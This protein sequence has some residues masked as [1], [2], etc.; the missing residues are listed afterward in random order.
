[1]ASGAEAAERPVPQVV[2]GSNGERADD[3]LINFW[4]ALG[5]DSTPGGK[6]ANLNLIDVDV[7]GAA[8]K[9]AA[10]V[11][12]GSV[13]GA[14]GAGYERGSN[15][16]SGSFGGRGG[17]VNATLNA[18][19]SGRGDQSAQ[20]PRFWVYSRGGVGGD[21]QKSPG[22]G[23]DAGTA[24]LT[25]S[26][27]V[28]T[29]GTAFQGVRVTS[30]GGNAGFGGRDDA[31]DAASRRGGAGGTAWMRLA[32]EAG[33]TTTGA[34][35]TGIVVESTGGAGSRKG[36]DFY[37]GDYATP[38]GTGG[39]ASIDN[40]GRIVTTGSHALGI[41]VQ[42]LGGNG[43]MQDPLSG[44]G[45]PGA[46]GGDGG[47][48][49]V[50]NYG[51]VST[52]GAYSL[53]IV[54]QS[55]G[56]PGGTGGG[57]NFGTGGT[58]GAAGQGG[59]VTIT[60]R[61][62]VTTTGKGATAIVAQSIGGGN[63]ASALPEG[64]LD[65]I[66]TASG[67]GQSGGSFGLFW[68]NGGAGGRGASG[69]LASVVNDGGVI[70][71]EG[72]NA[73]GMLI[74]SVG[75]SG[76]AGGLSSVA[77]GFFSVALGGSGGGGGAGG[78]AQF[79]G[80]AGRVETL[81]AGATAVLVQ[82][83]GGGGGVGGEARSTAGGFGLSYSKAVGGSG[84]QGGRGGEAVVETR[85]NMAVTTGGLAATGLSALSVGGGGGVGGLSDAKAISVP[86]V[87]P[88]GKAL[89]SVAISTSIG[90]SGGE[91]G[92][93]GQATVTHAGSVTT[94]GTRAVGIRAL[95]VGGGG[96]IGGDAAAYALAIAPPG[97]LAL[98]AASSLG[99][100][101]GKGGD[102]GKVEVTN[103]GS[104]RTSG[105]SAFG[106]QAQSTGG[107]GGD[108]GAAT[109]V[110]NALSL[111]QNVT[112][113]SAIGGGPQ[114][115]PLLDAQGRLQLDKNG[116]LLFENPAD[117]KDQGGGQGG[118]VTVVNQGLI[119]TG[120]ALATGILAQSI[121]GGGGNGGNATTLGGAGFSFDKT[122]DAQLHK[123]PLADNAALSMT[124]GGRGGRGGAGGEVAVTNGGTIRTAGT[125]AAGILAQSVGGGGGTGGEVQGAAK[126]KLDLKLTLG[127][128]GGTGNK[129]GAVTVETLAGSRIETT[130]DGAHGIVARSIGGGGGS[131]GN[132]SARKESTPD[133]VGAIW[134]Q[135]KQSIGVAAYE[136]W[137][138][139]KKNK[140]DKEALDQFL[141]D[142]K[143]SDTYKNLADKIKN[144]DFGKA[145][146]SYS[147]SVSAYLKEQKD[148]SVKLPD[149]SATLS[150]GGGGG[151]GGVGGA[152][153]VTNAGTILTQGIL[154]HG[155]DAQSVG[156]GGGQ[157]GLAFATA[158]NK[159]NF[160]GT[161]GGTGGSGNVGGTVEVVNSG[162]VV[163]AEDMSYGLS[164]QSVGGGGGR[165]VAATLVGGAKVGGAKPSGEGK[166]EGKKD[167]QGDGK[168][169][170]RSFNLTVG[171]NGGEGGNG[172]AVTVTNTGTVATAGIGAHGIVAQSVGGGGGSFS[173]PEAKSDAKGAAKGAAKGDTKAG[174]GE[175]SDSE[176]LVTAL[177]SA[178][179]IEKLAEP[180]T[181]GSTPEKS[182][183]ITLGGSGGASGTGGTVTVTHGGTIT[184]TGF[185]AFGLF[186]QSIGGGGG[187]VDGAASAGG[188]KYTFGLGGAGSASGN[189]GAITATLK[190]G[191]RVTTSGDAATAVMLQSIGGG[192]GYAGA[193]QVMGYAVPF[194]LRDGST[195]DGGAIIATVE[196]DAAIRTTGA[197]A[198]GIHAQSLGGGGGLVV[199][200]SGLTFA[201][202]EPPKGRT[203]SKG[204]GGDITITATGAVEALGKDAYAIFAQSGVQRSDGSLDPARSGGVIAVTAKGL[205]TGGTGTGAAIRIDGGGGNTITLDERA[206]VSAA[207]GR[208]IVGS[209]ADDRLVNR[210]TILGDIDLQGGS[211]LKSDRIEN[212]AIDW[213]GALLRSRPDGIINVGA[214]GQVLNYAVLDIGGVGTV[215]RTTI[216][217]DFQQL[218][219]GRLL[220]DVAPN[221]RDGALR[222]DLLV[223][224]GTATLGGTVQPTVTGGLLPGQY[225]F[226]TAGR[227]GETSA[228][229]PGTVIQP[230][231]IPISWAIVQAGNSLSLSP[232]A[233]FTT[234]GNMVLTGDQR[235][236]AQALQDD[237]AVSAAGA[238][239]RFAQFL[240]VG[241][242]A[243]Y[244][245]ALDEITPEANQYV[246]T[247]RTL[248]ARAGLKRAMS[249]P[250]FV[251]TGTLLREGEC[252]WGR[253]TGTRTSLFSSA[254]ESGY[255]QTALSYQGGLQ[256][257]FS[258]DWFFGLS[259][260]YTRA[261]QSGSDRV[262]GNVGDAGDLSV[263]LKHQVG[264]WLL[265]A[266]ANL[267]YSWQSNV[268]AIGIGGDTWLARSKSEVLTAGGRLRG[269]YQILFDG[270]YV[271][272]YADLDVLYTHSPAYSE[273]GA[274]AFNL[275]VRSLD[276]TLVAFS[277]NVEIGGRIDLDAGRWIRPYATLGVM[278]LSDN[279]FT[280]FAS[281][282][283]DGP[284][285]AFAT[286]SR[287]PDRLGEAGLGFQ[288][289]LGNGI[290]LTGEYQATVGDRYL[291]QTGTARMQVRF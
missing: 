215:A 192:G 64:T 100:T 276:K 274:P 50:F 242:T 74:Q 53:G 166:A 243:S 115:K 218:A 127:G 135:I 120:G 227:L 106:L 38:G 270:W 141:K 142:I 40:A 96:G 207:S 219:G 155:V 121:G 238:Q 282:R 73:Y 10:T 17:D 269:S 54:A 80:E 139:D 221:A 41:L 176:G 232:Q 61:G 151:T 290:E 85:D 140:D 144:S 154:S 228:T 1:M 170:V 55:V 230:G 131:G 222:S 265:A 281:F 287:I 146:Q 195:G 256:T 167:G 224:S 263:A 220:V 82:S 28:T 20:L 157:G 130:G 63:A 92:N 148:G 171:G 49:E 212:G 273:T 174:A 185:G 62:V 87:L 288:I 8:G 26:S 107:G 25:L 283:S 205:V 24:S 5:H 60:S 260:A 9:P 175:K 143:E 198:H 98:A 30:A 57:K 11:E 113:S 194:L 59:D 160:S 123:L 104:V 67:G 280:G 235:A 31:A 210:G 264:P 268:R 136:D 56:G 78:K 214:T 69:G 97:Q 236:V 39:K 208:A 257:E 255:R 201:T 190:Q 213:H 240:K 99:G 133:A 102:G 186:A 248:D 47:W 177:L 46:R 93:G 189:G 156:G 119:E 37:S 125:S 152:V 168:D 137:A 36:N 191:A 76:G 159:T 252:V 128:S 172:G 124:I 109:A 3:W 147:K 284:L 247:D 203:G 158:D 126:G 162:T 65:A 187:T 234:P 184:T 15:W 244:A 163:T 112:L 164:A 110:S 165:G 217:G 134:T 249:C 83:V 173:T 277:P 12:I 33:V 188:S 88:N 246:L 66:G 35:A 261:G 111:H 6:G 225:T 178:L 231:S 291:S 259:G 48:A 43:G 91:G 75:G 266:S 29:Q 216:T 250:A 145:L 169:E 286:S 22:G 84:G 272:P 237:W 226:L 258:P 289:G 81:G 16:R 180:E 204:K 209:L 202:P 34:R 2:R 223:V 254:E 23:G 233:N 138:K 68:G 90:G 52:T 79:I 267:G 183:G 94:Y 181:A 101:G 279:H 275:D 116:V 239:G 122:L 108:G 229:A 199:D 285:R 149:I 86:L 51:R 241:T 105:D 153:K 32:Q 251:G 182:Y 196:Q 21:G 7:R 132:V 72:A 14:G 129:G 45:H 89:P 19:L 70:A 161:V 13:G 118:S 44:G 262:T 253:I 71:T 200:L 18:T 179:G 27:M 150:I 4:G 103:R 278:L 114:L 245:D 77:G 193:H 211:A 58:G 197:Q 206:V 42:S 271:K 95:S 117:I